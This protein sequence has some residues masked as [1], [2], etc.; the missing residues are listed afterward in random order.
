MLG[1][2]RSCV[3]VAAAGLVLALGAGVW[4]WTGPRGVPHESVDFNRD[5]RPILN[6]NCTS[7]H[8]GVKQQGGVSFIYRE[9]ALGKGDS[10]RP[11]IVPGRPNASEL[12]ARVVSTDPEGRMPYRAPPLK[13][14]QI[15]L[16]KQW[17][18]EGAQWKE[19]WAF[20]PPT[21]REVPEVRRRDWPRQPLDRFILARLERESLQP[22]PEADKSALLRRVSLDLTGLPPTPREVAEFL[23]DAS[24]DAYEKQVDRLLASPRYGERWASM[25]L[26]LARY[27]DSKGYELDLVRPGVWPYRDWVI[28]A[29]NRNLPYDQFVIE[30]LAGDLLPNPTFDQLIA[31]AFHR[32]TPA[33]DEGGTDDE[34]YRLV[35]VMDRVATTWSVVNGLTINCV[36]CHAHPYDPVRHDEYYKSLAFF[37]TTRDADR[38]VD[39]SPMLPVP[40]DPTRRDETARLVGRR[41]ALQREI[42][43]AGRAMQGSVKW[44]GLPISQGKVDAALALDRYLSELKLSEREGRSP[45]PDQ[46]LSKAELRKLFDMLIPQTVSELRQAR[47]TPPLPLQIQSGAAHV[48]GTLPSR[49]VFELMTESTKRPANALRIEIPPESPQTAR[50]SP[51]EGFIVDQ[52]EAWTVSGQ[53]KEEK[54][55]FQ[56]FVPDSEENL[57]ISLKPPAGGAQASAA[58]TTSA[59]AANPKLFRT[60]SLIAIPKE[61]LPA[62][63]RIKLHLWHSKQIVLFK[64]ATVRRVT[65]STSDDARWAGWGHDAKQLARLAELADVERR[66]AAIPSVPLPVMVEQDAYEQRETLLF[67][68]GN[69]LTKVGSVLAPDVPAIFPSLPEGQPRNRLTMARWFFRPGQPLT[70]RVAVNRYWEQLF[71][72]GLVETLEDFGSAGESPSHP[73]LLDWLALHFQNDLGWDMKRLLK[74]LVTSSTYR[75]SARATPAALERDPANRLLARGPRQRLSAEMVRDQALAASGLLTE[76]IG[77]PPVMPPQPQSVSADAMSADNPF[78]KWVDAEGANRYRRSLYTILKRTSIYPSLTTFDA[79]ARSISL[80]RRVPTNTPLQ[81]LV[82]LN[83]P[84]YREAADALA[85]R[86]LE[87][88]TAESGIVRTNGLDAAKSVDRAVDRGLTYGA[89]SVISRVP[90]EQELESLRALYSRS[91]ASGS[92]TSSTGRRLVSAEL[93]AWKAVATALLNLDVALTR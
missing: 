52:V 71:G 45:D 3:L 11:A 64:P 84:V 8:G 82:T 41:A 31:T 88:S 81:A 20:V 74:E 76:S 33:N 93:A 57:A 2:P 16:L 7:C 22:S 21:T 26:D 79:S 1:A 46:Q 75:Q 72:T 60:R 19:Y 39:D 23:S 91:L 92:K 5:I 47:E 68:R 25:W 80:P 63:V 83:D 69:F 15:A 49:S 40:T 34:E 6:Q 43:E 53:G 90:S 54:I 56:Y 86:M 77:G 12:I 62:G 36:Q 29:F 78:W 48:E 59:F 28:G 24:S 32:Q 65:V 66:L 55:A 73:E 30:Q 61:S 18:A 70:A 67:E 58:G 9:E 17:I 35:A 85:K 87:A 27:A 42:V 44:A 50:H 14:K 51:E 13:P 4:M 38:F 37:N 10:G 89:L